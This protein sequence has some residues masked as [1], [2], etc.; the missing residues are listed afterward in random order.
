[1]E[2]YIAKMTMTELDN[3]ILPTMA[4]KKTWYSFKSPNI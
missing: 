1:M 2:D 3:I 4:D